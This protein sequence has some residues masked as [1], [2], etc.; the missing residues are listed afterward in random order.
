MEIH[1]AGYGTE[2]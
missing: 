2:V 1:S